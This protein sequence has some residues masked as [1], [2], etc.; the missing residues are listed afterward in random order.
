MKKITKFFKNKLPEGGFG[1]VFKVAIADGHE[2]AVK[3]LKTATQEGEEFLNEVASIGRTSHIN[4]VSH[5]GFCFQGSKSP[6]IYDFMT[7]GS[8]YKYIF[9]EDPKTTIGWEK[10][11]P[12][13]SWL[14]E[15]NGAKTFRLLDQICKSILY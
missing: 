13:S 14:I 15:H 11:V 8:L 12:T 9:A 3:L 10:L 2:V 1:T 6:L 4:I 7:N 5:L